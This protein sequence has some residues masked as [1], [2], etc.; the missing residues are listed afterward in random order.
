[1]VCGSSGFADAATALLTDAGVD[2]DHIRVERFGPS[3]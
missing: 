3:G 1:Y 2:V